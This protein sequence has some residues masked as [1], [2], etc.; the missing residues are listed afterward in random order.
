MDNLL[1]FENI[2]TLTVNNNNDNSFMLLLY[3]NIVG[4]CFIP[5]FILLCIYFC[6]CNH[7][8]KDKYLLNLNSF[9]DI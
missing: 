6:K 2:T 4:I 3:L 7:Y 5:I 1:K 9:E 8:N